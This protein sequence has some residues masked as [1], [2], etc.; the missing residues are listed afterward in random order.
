MSKSENENIIVTDLNEYSPNSVPETSDTMYTKLCQIAKMDAW[1]DHHNITGINDL[2]IE[3]FVKRHLPPT[4]GCYKGAAVKAPPGTPSAGK[5][6]GTGTPFGDGRPTNED[7]FIY[8]FLLEKIKRDDGSA[9]SLCKPNSSIGYETDYGRDF[10]DEKMVLDRYQVGHVPFFSTSGDDDDDS[11][12]SPKISGSTISPEQ[13]NTSQVQRFFEEIGLNQ[14]IYIIRDVAYGNWADDIKKWGKG[15][16]STGETKI[17]TVQSAAGIFDPGPSTN[18]FTKGG[19][20]QGFQDMQ[21]K[22]RYAIFDVENDN[23]KYIPYPKVEENEN[24]DE[25]DTISRG[26]LLYTRYN[27]KLCASTY[28][29]PYGI[30]VSK[31]D[32]K[33]F[34]ESAGVDFIVSVDDNEDMSKRVYTNSVSSSSKDSKKA[35][36]VLELSQDDIIKTLTDKDRTRFDF[37]DFAEDAYS[38]V[39]SSGKLKIMTKKFG[40]HG[41][42]VT[43]CKDRLN[44]LLIEPVDTN[45]KDTAENFTIS[46]GTSNGVHAFL[47]FDRVAVA[48]AVYYGC[49]IVIYNNHDGAI[50]F[51]SRNMLDKI[52]T[53]E[54]KA[55]MASKNYNNQ[56]LRSKKLI[57]TSQIDETDPDSDSERDYKDFE[58]ISNTLIEKIETDLITI[59]NFI[60]IIY[61][62][63]NTTEINPGQASSLDIVYQTLVIMLDRISAPIK[64]V[65]SF[66]GKYHN[67]LTIE[68]EI[69]KLNEELIDKHL[70]IIEKNKKI[71]KKKITDKYYTEKENLFQEYGKKIRKLND[72][73]SSNIN[74]LDVI[75]N[76]A[77]NLR[78]IINDIEIATKKKTIF[79]QISSIQ[80]TFKNSEANND[81]IKLLNPYVGTQKKDRRKTYQAGNVYVN[82]GFSILEDIYSSMSEEEINGLTVKDMFSSILKRVRIEVNT[83]C[84]DF[85][86]SSIGRN[87]EALSLIQIRSLE[88]QLSKNKTKLTT[89]ENKKRKKLTIP[90]IK[91]LK[92]SIKSLEN[93]LEIAKGSNIIYE[94]SI[95]LLEADT[96]DD[97]M[98]IEKKGGK[99]TRKY[100]KGKT[101]KRKPKKKTKKNK[102]KQKG[103]TKD[104]CINE[105]DPISMEELDLANMVKFKVR[106]A[107]KEDNK[108]YN[109]YNRDTLKEHI[110]KKIDL[111]VSKDDIKDP[112]T[113][114]TIDEDFIRTNYPELLEA[115]SELEDE[116]DEE[117]DPYNYDNDLTDKQ[118]RALMH[119]EYIFREAANDYVYTYPG[120]TKSVTKTSTPQEIF[121]WYNKLEELRSREQSNR[122]GGKSKKNKKKYIKRNSKKTKKK[123]G[124]DPILVSNSKPFQPANTETEEQL[125]QQDK[126]LKNIGELT[127]NLPPEEIK[128][129]ENRLRNDYNL[130]TMKDILT[131]LQ[132]KTQQQQQQMTTEKEPEEIS[133][134][135][136][137]N[138]HYDVFLDVINF[139]I[140]INGTNIDKQLILSTKTK[141]GIRNEHKKKLILKTMNLNQI[142]FVLETVKTILTNKV[143][144]EKQTGGGKQR[145]DALIKS[146]SVVG[147]F[148][149]RAKS[150]IDG[151]LK[152]KF[153]TNFNT[154]KI[155]L[156]EYAEL[157]NKD[158]PFVEKNEDGTYKIIGSYDLDI[159]AFAYLLYIL[160][161][162]GK[163]IKPD[164]F[165]SLKLTLLNNANY[166]NEMI[167]TTRRNIPEY[168]KENKEEYKNILKEH[169]KIDSFSE[170]DN[171]CPDFH[172][173]IIMET[174]V[175]NSGLLATFTDFL[176]AEYEMIQQPSYNEIT[177]RTRQSEIL[178]Q[179]KSNIKTVNKSLEDNSPEDY[180][181]ALGVL[182]QENSIE[183]LEII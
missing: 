74:N 101:L 22:S 170:Y 75:Q 136:K 131:E 110:Q 115:F 158:K 37:K 127:N 85:F 142:L 59:K 95:N 175:P 77:N 100:R 81:I 52:N 15:N 165:K 159:N 38:R 17:I 155:D 55:E 107:T 45:D 6:V 78:D 69:D 121:N 138:D 93:K 120:A 19:I 65:R 20:R 3:E 79:K 111:K 56:I 21:S 119:H 157:S 163:T 143:G 169:D 139:A 91:E 26:Q 16:F 152:T 179:I 125:E 76:I 86:L 33:N 39:T 96:F 73:L 2:E 171:N 34:I 4:I 123:R 102:R 80:S 92:H 134:E 42:A 135:L 129:I 88:E 84:S 105:E 177:T 5:T 124:G 166:F 114:K 51:V 8:R 82:F 180:T 150:Y 12:F 25:E 98:E 182:E 24:D 61:D 118:R 68:N 160:K 89:E 168:N 103:G 72:K 181:V 109:C 57:K 7:I 27:C 162:G 164:E 130:S 99:K 167:T 173:L 70:E 62:Y 46:K 9:Q 36:N 156:L 132:N 183:R 30:T 151:Y 106:E 43:A 178:E 83:E 104:D 13:E 133:A 47:S 172:P 113:N 71:N 116:Y 144:S 108:I 174:M 137:L 141:E 10:Y 64:I 176:T 49:P 14:D 128:K 44:H 35:K 146:I 147:R 58:A 50:I 149:G 28:P 53:P 23:E 145:L 87:D 32:T 97:I 140:G 67:V 126:I 60:K 161:N 148:Q 112:L 54:K 1:H 18:P 48:S 11:D 31:K 94:Q 117:M 90:L 63:L 41:Q 153:D 29:Q 66:N 154:M 122:R 40:D